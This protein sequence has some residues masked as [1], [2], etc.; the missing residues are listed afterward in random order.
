MPTGLEKINPE[1][2]RGNQMQT[3]DE[4]FYMEGINLSIDLGPLSPITDVA[5]SSPERFSPTT[6]PPS[7]TQSEIVKGSIGP[8]MISDKEDAGLEDTKQINE[9]DAFKKKLMAWLKNNNPKLT[10]NSFVDI[11][12][13]DR[14][15]ISEVNVMN[16][17]EKGQNSSP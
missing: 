16:L 3:K 5:I 2:E 17:Y 12:N 14:E 4:I 7:P 6:P 8:M 15:A 1:K 10:T 11:E 13:E 9:E